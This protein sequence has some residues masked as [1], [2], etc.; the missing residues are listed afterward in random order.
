[1]FLVKIYQSFSSMNIQFFHSSII[2]VPE[3]LTANIY[4]FKVSNKNTREGVKYV[5]S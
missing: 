1:M 4:L 5:Q 3:N 2:T